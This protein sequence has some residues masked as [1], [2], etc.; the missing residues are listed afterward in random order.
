MRKKTDSLIFKFA[1]VFA[2]FTVVTL[3]LTGVTTYVNQKSS[4]QKQCKE[5]IGNICSYLESLIQS[6]AENFATLQNWWVKNQGAVLIPLD[7]DGDWRPAKKDFD[8]LFAKKYPGKALGVDIDFLS[9]DFDCQKAWAKWQFEYW[10]NVFESARPAFGVFYTYYMVPRGKDHHIYWMI[11]A[12]REPYENPTAETEGMIDLLDDYFEET[13]DDYPKAKRAWETGERTT[14]YDEYDNEYGKTYAYVM[15]LVIN[16]K[17]YGIIGVDILVDKFL[18]EIR[19]QTLMQMAQ[20]GSIFLV[21]VLL[22]LIFI[23]RR[24]ISKLVHL[25]KQVREYTTAKDAGVVQ[26]IEH[27]SR[28]HDEIAVLSTQVAAMIMELENYI[29]NLIAT[30]K[31]LTD[32]KALAREMNELAVKDALTGIRNKTAYDR[33]V[34]KLTWQIAEG[35]TDFG[36]AVIDLNYL[37]RVNDTYGH[38]Q[39]NEVIKRLCKIVCTVF[40]HSPVFRIGGDEFAIIL[41]GHDLDYIKELEASFFTTLDKTGREEGAEPWEKISAAIGIAIFE[42]GRDETVDNVFKRADKAMYANKKAMKA[43]RD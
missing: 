21:A 5:N 40:D 41:K 17:T 13:I 23:Y 11:D 39:G 18:A 26:T 28:G 10:L 43:T 6:D 24:Y 1:I 20:L 22:T 2:V 34:S 3:A 38:E 35:L 25:Q 42:P 4:Y 19:R 32:T 14:D 31:E 36:I 27:D 30:T 9:L 15:P 29:K 16:R 33:E 37:K 12:V 7:F 8:R